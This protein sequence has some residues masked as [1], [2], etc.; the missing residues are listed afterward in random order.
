MSTPDL[1]GFGVLFDIDGTLVD[2]NY[3]HAVS[4]ADAFRSC[5]YD[6]ATSQLHHLIGQG[7]DRLVSS[8]LGADDR[9][10]SE[11]HSDFYRPHLH[12]LRAFTGAADLIRKVKAT[13][14]TVVLATSASKADAQY[15][16]E[17]IDAA[18]AVDVVIT[19]DDVDTS[20]PDPD[21]VDAALRSGDLDAAN[22]VFVGDSV[23]DVEAAERAGLSCICVLTGGIDECALRAAGA[24]EIYPDVA[25]LADRLSNSLIGELSR[26]LK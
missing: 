21:I 6:V 25:T 26:R 12:H 17:A 4:W 18:D 15:L 23:W 10:V 14:A 24:A 20:K 11:A 13:G 22:C 5:G 7:S 8:V 16:V 1:G 3:L 9:A 2:T 19:N